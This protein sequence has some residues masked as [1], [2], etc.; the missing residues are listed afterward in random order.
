M[1]CPFHGLR[2]S[3]T[4]LEFVAGI[5]SQ[6]CFPGPVDFDSCRAAVRLTVLDADMGGHVL[7]AETNLTFKAGLVCTV[8][9]MVCT[10]RL[11]DVHRYRFAVH[12]VCIEAQSDRVMQA[13]Q[14]RRRYTGANFAN[15]P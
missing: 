9:R 15:R 10:G 7:S 12:L 3:T 5:R 2:D 6:R 13:I 4:Q 1:P 14:L 11:F 8:G